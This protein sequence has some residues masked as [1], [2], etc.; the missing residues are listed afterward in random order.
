[1]GDDLVVV[2]I[3]HRVRPTST[4][5]MTSAY[6]Q[7]PTSRARP[8]LVH[9]EG[10]ERSRDR[11]VGQPAARLATVPDTDQRTRPPHLVDQA[12]MLGA[13]VATVVA[14][15][16]APGP[17]DMSDLLT[18]V[19]VGL[20]MLAFVRPK[21][22]HK[23]RGRVWAEPLAIAA[24]GALC[25]F[26]IVAMPVQYA[27]VRG[28]FRVTNGEQMGAL[29]SWTVLPVVWAAATTVIYRKIVGRP[30]SHAESAET[31]PVET[32]DQTGTSDLGRQDPEQPV[33]AS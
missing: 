17:W 32:V 33:E 7:T 22:T 23:L 10:A 28:V 31:A 24:V 16:G 12:A 6:G 30:T 8:D 25:I 27:I 5:A 2:G 19:T 18:G 3:S 13:V 11:R 14:I 1:M 9:T 21:L 15:D 20:V 4:S 29:T 26:L